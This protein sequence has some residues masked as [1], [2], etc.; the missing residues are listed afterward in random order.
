VRVSVTRLRACLLPWCLAG[1]VAMLPAAHAAVQLDRTRVVLKQSDA[2]ATVTASNLDTLPVLLQVWV[3]PGDDSLRATAYGTPPAP[4][5]F[6]VDPPVL[7]LEPDDARALQVWLTE[8]PEHL[9]TDRESQ[10]WLNVLEIPAEAADGDAAQASQGARLDIN[11]L[12]RIKL[13]YRPEAL[14]GYVP[15]TSTDRL[16]FALERQRQ[17]PPRLTIQNPAPIHQSLDK[18]SLHQGAQE[19]SVSLDGAMV[20]P[21]G[22][23]QIPLPPETPVA[24][25]GLWIKVVTID[26]NGS[27]IEDAQDL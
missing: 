26:D 15:H 6:L 21:F 27:L 2:K 23:L 11:I 17:N 18:L 13:F 5:P 16:Q 20:A 7:R 12:T 25:A 22:Q 19:H 3:E 9:P 10:F 24:T 14:K 1:V 4:T 8:A